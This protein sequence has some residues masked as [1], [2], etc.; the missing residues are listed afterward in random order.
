[1]SREHR[2]VLV[3]F[4]AGPSPPP[5]CLKELTLEGRIT[6]NRRSLQIRYA[7]RGPLQEVLIPAPAAVPQ[8]RDGLWESTCLEAFVALPAEE[9]YWELNLSPAG[10][11]NV[12]RL[13][14][15]RRGLHPEPACP[16]LPFRLSRGPDTLQLDLAWDLPVE[17][18][19]EQPLAVGLTAVIAHRDGGISHWALVHPGPAADFHH[20]EGFRLRL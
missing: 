2:F 1:M 14:G 3:P 10:H 7:L 19:P 18:G 13:E 4:Q 16:D 17:I 5:A 6:R 12:Y 15:Y 20:R 11:W 8:R 9:G